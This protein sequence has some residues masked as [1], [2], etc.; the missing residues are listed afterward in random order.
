MFIGCRHLREL[1]ESQREIIERHVDR[2]KW[3]RHI[4]S[5]E[6]AISDFIEKFGWIMRE[7]HCTQVCTDRTECEQPSRLTSD[8]R[9]PYSPPQ[10]REHPIS[11]SRLEL[12]RCVEVAGDGPL[13]DKQ[14]SAPAFFSRCRH[15]DML[16]ESQADIIQRHLERH[17]WFRRI[18]NR[19]EAL[20]D[21]V[22]EFGWVMRELYCGSI[23]GDRRECPAEQDRP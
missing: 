21:F 6:A 20:R 1:L 2:H 22:S 12:M 9:L 10:R 15:L 23:C 11:P 3:F 14:A 13:G 8:G 18:D 16:L 4:D 5:R 19:E 7:F 17:M